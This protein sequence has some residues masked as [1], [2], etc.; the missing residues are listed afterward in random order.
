M[1]HTHKYIYGDKNRL[2]N[3]ANEVAHW[4]ET[5]TQCDCEYHKCL[6]Q[7]DYTK[8]GNT[9]EKCFRDCVKIEGG[10]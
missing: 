6:E 9:C 5:H 7:D 3:H 1:N 4:C 2:W 8:D 10:K